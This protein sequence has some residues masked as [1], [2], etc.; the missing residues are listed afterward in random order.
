[1]AHDLL[2]VGVL[3]IGIFSECVP[4]DAADIEI[5]FFCEGGLAPFIVVFYLLP[6]PCFGSD[7]F[8][9]LQPRVDL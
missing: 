4:G 3:L 9:V 8:G 5:C 7:Y 2:R 1:M 6:W